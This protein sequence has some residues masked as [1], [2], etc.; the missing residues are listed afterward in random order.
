MSR[1]QQSQQA[2]QVSTNLQSNFLTNSTLI[3]CPNCQISQ[4]TDSRGACCRVLLPIVS[5]RGHR[6]SE[7][8][9]WTHQLTTSS[10]KFVFQSHLLRFHSISWQIRSC[11]VSA[12]Q[13]RHADQELHVLAAAAANRLPI[14]DLARHTASPCRRHVSVKASIPTL[15][16]LL[17]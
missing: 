4:I 8:D 2:H 14:P 16:A 10:H 13:L 17:F 5:W 9:C 15:L 12:S 3:R 11:V 7:H 1:R 6:Q